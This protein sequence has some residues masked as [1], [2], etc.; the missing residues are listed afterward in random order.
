MTKE[1]ILAARETLGLNVAEMSRALGVHRDTYSKWEREHEKQKATAVAI[2]AIRLLLFLHEHGLLCEW[3][4]EA[5][6]LAHLQSASTA[7]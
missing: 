7:L 5:Q 6:C 3:L 4:S 1:E 2:T